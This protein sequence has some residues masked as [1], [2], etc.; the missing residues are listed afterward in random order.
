MSIDQIQR[1]F[2]KAGYQWQ[3]NIYNDGK[4]ECSIKFAIDKSPHYFSEHILGDFG[5]GRF[6]RLWAWRQAYEWLQKKQAA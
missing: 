2:I 1:A 4:L 3:E 5:W 6:D